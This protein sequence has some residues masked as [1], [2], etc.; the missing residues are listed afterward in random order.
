MSKK[1]AT[2]KG[3]IEVDT[4]EQ[5]AARVWIVGTAPIILNRIS[6]KAK[7][8]LL[9]PKGKKTTAEKQ[10]TLKHN[11][12]QEFAAAP[13]VNADTSAPTYLQILST[14]VKNAM[15]GA[16]LD[17]PG[18]VSK[19]AITRLCYVQGE[20]INLY[21]VPKLH[22]AIVRQSGMNRTPDVRTRAIVPQW[23]A[24][25]TIN[26]ASPMLKL[27]AVLNLLSAGGMTQGLGDWR[28]EKNGSYGTY[29]VTNSD[30]LELRSIIKN[31]ARTAQIDAMNIPVAY[32]E[33]S[34]ELLSWFSGQATSRGFHV[35][36]VAQAEVA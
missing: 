1:S 33:E 6:E 36:P 25:V 2:D 17:M 14:S 18:D 9:M 34:E 20:K 22:M 30:D 19:S 7:R 15:R 10:S 21:G 32:N 8:E 24:E 26:Y 11:P 4:V 28:V 3:V 27:P 16:A 12:F 5:C 29:R 13:Y 35:E 31:G 23:A